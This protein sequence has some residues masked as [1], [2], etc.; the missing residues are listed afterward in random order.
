LLH[1]RRRLPHAP[2]LE[3]NFRT[4]VHEQPQPRKGFGNQAVGEGAIALNTK[5]L[6]NERLD[7]PVYG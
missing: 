4:G 1:W 5:I 7:K 2:L 3:Q 6:E